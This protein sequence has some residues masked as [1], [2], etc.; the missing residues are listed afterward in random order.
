M[1]LVYLTR[2]EA[3]NAAHKLHR[4]E[5]SDEEN[6]RFFGKCSNPNW[7][8]HNY[9]LLITV[10]GTPDPETGYVINL[11]TLSQLIRAKVLNDLD[12]KNLNLDV[13]WMKGYMPSTEILAMRIWERLKDGVREMGA[14]LHSVKIFETENNSAEYFG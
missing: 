9:T 10:K 11:K 12:H 7:H 2:K 1:G 3:F 14:E 13:E 5:W 8:G 4:T 6:L